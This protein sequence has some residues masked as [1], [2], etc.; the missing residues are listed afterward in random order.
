MHRRMDELFGR[1]GTLEASTAAV[2]EDITEMKP[3]T[4]GV[5]KWKLMGIGALGVIGIGG[6]ALGVTF[7]DV[8]KR[9][10]AVLL[11]GEGYASGLREGTNLCSS[12]A[13]L[14]RAADKGAARA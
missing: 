2:Q 12:E 11:R 4:D 10:L 14:T 5:R 13:S 8:V 3:I 6:A 7:A 1:V 9:G